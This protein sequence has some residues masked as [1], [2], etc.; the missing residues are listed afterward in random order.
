VECS[1]I[2]EKLSAFIDGL[3]SV[4]EQSF[5]DEHLR[6][7]EKCRRS[8]A[9]MKQTVEHVR[10]VDKVEP[11]PWLARKVMAR[12]KQENESRRGLLH[13][14]FYPLHIKLPLEAMATIGVAVIAFYLFKSMP[15]E[16]KYVQAPSEVVTP[17]TYSQ[18]EVKLP[19]P[20]KD[21]Y[22][23]KSKVTGSAVVKEAGKKLA[24]ESIA[25]PEPPRKRSAPPAD[26]V[27]TKGIIAGEEDES[28]SLP[29][30]GKIK[31]NRVAQPASPGKPESPERHYAFE[32]KAKNLQQEEIFEEKRTPHSSERKATSA[33]ADSPS[34]DEYGERSTAG[35]PMTNAR[36][37]AT[38]R[39]LSLK[40]DVR[41]SETVLNEIE[42]VVSGFGGKIVNREHK[43]DKDII[44]VMLDYKHLRAFTKELE[45]LGTIRLMKEKKVKLSGSIQITIEVTE[46]PVRE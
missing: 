13:K 5:V 20:E 24:P 37:L 4:E 35:T 38:D 21:G 44:T 3:L 30:E 46:A 45:L 6:S 19:V 31:G 40:L 10:N 2:D 29:E 27:E 33:F 16:M 9:E 22:R 8:L 43:K 17:Q 1:K 7:C 34:A 28:L 41:E 26:Y 23:D 14:L 39:E 25:E 11:P 18:K 15:S 42:R 36:L 32:Y 12:I